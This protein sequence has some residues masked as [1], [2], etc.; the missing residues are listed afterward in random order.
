MRRIDIDLN[1]FSKSVR[2]G[3]VESAVLALEALGDV[4][5]SDIGICAKLLKEAQKPV[6]C[7]QK[8]VAM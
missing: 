4:V 3:L 6:R 7:A 2:S 8:T 1:V 5:A